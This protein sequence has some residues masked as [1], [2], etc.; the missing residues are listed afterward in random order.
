MSDHRDTEDVERDRQA[1]LCRR[2]DEAIA[3][4]LETRRSMQGPSAQA[5]PA[6]SARRRLPPSLARRLGERLN[7]KKADP[8]ALPGRA[9]PPRPVIPRPPRSVGP[10]SSVARSLGAS[11]EVPLGAEDRVSP[12]D[13]SPRQLDEPPTEV[14]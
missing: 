14:D 9:L 8:G 5:T 4:S 6:T 2:G 13:G 3:E 11:D 1:E 7:G 12:E 10:P